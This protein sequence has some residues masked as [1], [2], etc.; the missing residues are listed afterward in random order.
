LPN[1]RSQST[2]GWDLPIIGLDD[3][4]PF[5]HIGAMCLAD[6]D[7]VSLNKEVIFPDIINLVDI[8]NIGAMNFHEVLL[9]YFL[10][11]ILDGIVGDVLF[12]AG[13]EF[14]IVSHTFY[15]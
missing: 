14:H 3:I 15:K 2:N 10:F 11:E 7:L 9:A 5:H 12:I 8:D 1:E 4:Q 13:Y 6:R